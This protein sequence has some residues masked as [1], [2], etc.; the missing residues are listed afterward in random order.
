MTFLVR[1]V[2]F[3]VALALALPATVS[4]FHSLVH[5][6]SGRDVLRRGIEDVYARELR[7]ELAIGEVLEWGGDLVRARDVTIR[8]PNGTVVIEAHEARLGLDV[9]ALFAGQLHFEDVKARDAVVRVLP[10]EEERTSLEEAFA[11]RGAPRP[12]DALAIDTGTMRVDGAT[13][14]VALDGPEVRL[15]DLSGFVRVVRP[16]DQGARVRLD[17]IEGRY[18]GPGSRLLGEPRFDAD[19]RVRVR[20]DGTEVSVDARIGLDPPMPVSVNVRGGRVR[21]AV[22]DDDHGGLGAALRIAG[23]FVG[24]LEVETE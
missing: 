12:H 10:G 22:D 6:D 23:V 2:I 17:R 5:T 3:A 13:L 20:P 16:K 11:S 15:E 1:L 18:L 7:G 9:A 24:S 8:A 19:G 21:V 14:V 4:S